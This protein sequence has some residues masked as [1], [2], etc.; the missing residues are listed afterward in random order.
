[1]KNYF[2][3]FFTFLLTACFAILNFSSQ[4]EATVVKG[5]ASIMNGDVAGAKAEAKRQAM[6]ELVEQVAGVKIQSTVEVS[7]NMLVRDEILSK[8]EGYVTIN[9]IIKEEVRG[10]VFYI[11]L[12]ATASTE[13]IRSTATDLRSKVEA[14]VNDSNSRGGILTAV[15]LRDRGRYSYDPEIS[16]YVNSK[17]KSVGF[18]AVGNDAVTK[19]LI[20]HGDDPDVRIQARVTARN[21]RTEENALLRGVLAIEE[22]NRANGGLYEA[23]AKASFEMIGLDSNSVDVFSKYFKAVGTSERDAIEQ[24]KERATEEAM[25]SIAMQALETV[26]QEKQ[27]GVT[28]IKT[29]IVFDGITDYTNQFPAIKAA[30][31]KANCKIVR[32]TRPSPTKLSFFISTDSYSNVGELQMT[33]AESIPGLEITEDPNA[34]GASKIQLLFKG[35]A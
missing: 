24:A 9:K 8:S 21:N 16:D 32:V 12:D 13:K 19:Y 33:L 5:Y 29:T 4:A 28:N 20:A 26:Q 3:R 27:G 10:D 17:L 30:L 15:V 6:R 1:M 18:Y 35:G 23:V 34:V 7:M 14:N 2:A 22:V 31:A 25:K 11:E